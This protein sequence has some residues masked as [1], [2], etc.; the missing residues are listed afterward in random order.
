ML[1]CDAGIIPVVMRGRS[2][3]LDLGRA[4]RTW[5]RAQRK[6]AKIRARGHCGAPKCQTPIERCELHHQ[7]HWARG[8][9]TDL[10]SGICLCTHHHWVTHHSTWTLTRNK[11][12]PVE[13]RRT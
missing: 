11:Q 2:E 5:T 7:D 13:I 10:N 9:R 8:G 6:A 1:A 12:G 4:T 3:I